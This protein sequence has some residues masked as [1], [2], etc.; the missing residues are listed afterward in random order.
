MEKE[1]NYNLKL[2]IRAITMYEKL[3]GKS[4]IDFELEQES[5]L[6][7]AYCIIVSHPENKVHCT[8][9][10][11]HPV[12]CNEKIL[13]PIA[14]GIKREIEYLKQFEKED[15][16]VTPLQTEKAG[17]KQSGFIKD[18]VPVLVSDCG[19]SI[20]YVMDDMSY[21][22]IESFLNYRDDKHK[23][24]LEE[25]RLFTYMNTI[26]HMDPKKCKTM[27]ADKWLPFP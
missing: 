18:L 3:S 5:V 23:N 25:Q 21:M 24:Q 22:D 10:E 20:E 26:V 1:L 6:Q 12:L 15:E 27:T 19:L 2:T 8:Y 13:E 9:R 7:L 17:K 14:I 16:P 11:L 4:F